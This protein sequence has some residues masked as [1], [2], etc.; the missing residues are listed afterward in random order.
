MGIAT[1]ILLVLLGLAATGALYY[2]I[3]NALD[4]RR[5]PPPGRK[6]PVNGHSLH[7]LEMGSGSPTV[8]FEAALGATSR[9]WALVQPEIA[10]HARTAAYERA[11]FG[12]SDRGPKPRV[13]SR[14]VTELRALLANAGLPPP[15]VF[16]GHSFG[17]LIAHLFAAKYPGETAGLVLVDAPYPREWIDLPPLNRR[18][19]R[20]GAFLCRRAVWICRLGIARLVARLAARG[21]RNS[22]R[23]TVTLLTYGML[24]GHEDRL[25]A[26]LWRLPPELRGPLQM[27]W[28]QPKFY[29][30]LA[31]QME[32]LPMSCA[33]VEAAGGLGDLPLLVLSAGNPS[34]E[35]IAQQ[36]AVTQLSTRG[37]HRV[38]SNPSHWI[39]LEEPELVIRAIRDV[40]AM[41]RAE[42]EKETAGERR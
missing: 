39:Q 4:A 32:H 13:A 33:E 25:L 40:L 24:R 34:P 8:I 35:R 15:Y 18:K 7:L 14:I 5:Y 30:A 2:S 16:V 20:G 28:T 12:W 27:F 41:A 26:P 1:I 37:E 36:E 3:G 42:K 38:S 23:N 10:R 17:G 21:Q 11:G 29:E 22:A 9:S 19:L 31:S 6:I